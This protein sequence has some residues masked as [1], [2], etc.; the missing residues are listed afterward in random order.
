M[1]SALNYV[2]C[3]AET[4]HFL[5]G[6]ASLS[7]DKVLDQLTHVTVFACLLTPVIVL[8]QAL[9]A[10]GVD[11]KTLLGAVRVDRDR[12]VSAVP[13]ARFRFAT[14]FRDVTEAL[15]PRPLVVFIDDLDRCGPDNVLAVLE[16]VNFLVSGG[17]CYIAL[18]LSRPWV[19]AA[20][21]LGFEK[22]AA[23]TAE[24]AAASAEA[25][26][27]GG[28]AP[29]PT[30]TD[31]R[32]KRC[33]FARHYLEKLVNIEVPVPA[34]DDSA[35][36][37]ILTPD[38]SAKPPRHLRA[39]ISQTWLP[40]LALATVIG[41]WYVAARAPDSIQA[42]EAAPPRGPASAPAA[43][44]PTAAFGSAPV[45]SG[46]PPP[47]GPSATIVRTPRRTRFAPGAADALAAIR[48]LLAA[49]LGTLALLTLVV[50]LVIRRA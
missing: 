3:H 24:S 42:A 32:D 11:P 36:K 43:V 12:A 18:G 31:A 46:H 23:E 13:G 38:A 19:E 16:T 22:I 39:L 8:V 20:V 9:R 48:V 49:A 45:P 25:S 14:E 50:V 44:D 4:G 30:A 28:R 10:F 47:T 41:G 15:K 34:L 21:G 17:D 6:L 27:N 5:V 40:T 33:R 2:R 26:P 7:A 29:S 1:G 37:D 35:S